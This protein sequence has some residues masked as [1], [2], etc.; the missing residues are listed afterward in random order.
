MEWQNG[1]WGQSV[2]VS[3]TLNCGI[4]QI[5]FDARQGIVFDQ[6]GSVFAHRQQL[7]KTEGTI[8]NN[9]INIPAYY[10]INHNQNTYRENV[11]TYFIIDGGK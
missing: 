10:N 9:E 4:T 5:D 8:N 1:T 11:N 6:N 7:N 2:R 3:N